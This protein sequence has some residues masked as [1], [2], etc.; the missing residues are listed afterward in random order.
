MKKADLHLMN[1]LLS[2]LDRINKISKSIH[3]LWMSAAQKVFGGTSNR[4][5]SSYTDACAFALS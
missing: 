4:S 1:G 3:P 2:F 5:S